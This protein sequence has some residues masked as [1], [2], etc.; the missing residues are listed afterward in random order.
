[1]RRSWLYLAR[2]HERAVEPILIW[3][4]PIG[5]RTVS[6]RFG[7]PPPAA[8]AARPS[9]SVAKRPD[10]CADIASRRWVTQVAFPPRRRGS[11]AYSESSV[12][13]PSVA[14]PAAGG[15]FVAGF[16][17]LPAAVF[18]GSR[19]RTPASSSSFTR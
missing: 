11:G 1:M 12:A 19:S 9:M 7:H 4:A 15:A 2:R 8:A 17:L 5:S 16:V 10:D 3:P 14:E 6:A 18:M 13:S